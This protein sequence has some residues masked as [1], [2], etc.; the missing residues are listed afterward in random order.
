MAS[1]PNA[2]S[3]PEPLVET[4]VK[5]ETEEEGDKAT[6]PHH[7]KNKNFFEKWIDQFKK[8]IEN[9]VD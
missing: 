9:D 8:F 2:K 1:D 7:T 6:T 3:I 4:P 5:T